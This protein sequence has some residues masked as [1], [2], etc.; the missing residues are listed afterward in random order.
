MLHRANFIGNQLN[1]NYF[2]RTRQTFNF[3][4]YSHKD[5]LHIFELFCQNEGYIL[6]DAARQKI[7]DNL[8]IK[9]PI[10]EKG[11]GN[12]RYIRNIF[13]DI[14]LKQSERISHSDINKASYLQ[15]ITA[16]DIVKMFEN[17]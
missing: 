8:F 1:V 4:D 10:R 17:Q 16:E 12:G 15:E 6:S 2:F 13:E 5:L 9:A 7:A 11:F 3:S 14:L